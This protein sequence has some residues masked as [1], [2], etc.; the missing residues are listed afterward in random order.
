MIRGAIFDFDGTLYDSMF[1]WRTIGEE[2]LRSIGY[3]PREDLS[4]TFKSMSLYQA[5]CYYQSEYGVKLSADEIMD[6][7]NRMIEHFYQDVVMP[8][9]GV[10][11]FLQALKNNGVRSCIASATDRYLLEA[12]LG[13]CGMDGFFSEIL[14]C[15]SVGSGKDE[16]V[17]FRE[18]LRHLGTEKRDT[19]VFEDALYAIETAKNDDFFVVGVYDKYEKNQS[20]AKRKVDI[21]INDYSDKALLEACFG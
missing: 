19:F 14:T 11:E 17:I 4:M 3:T 6:G 5:A 16:P 10:R 13:R 20:E 12:A 18:A 2:Y 9:K 21:Y 8:K 1:V 7:V 15:S